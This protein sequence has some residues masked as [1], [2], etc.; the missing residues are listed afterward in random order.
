MI[1]ERGKEYYH[2]GSDNFKIGKW[3]YFDEQ[4][5]LLRVEDKEGKDR[6][7]DMTYKEAFR[8]VSCHFGFSMKNLVIEKFLVSEGLFWVFTKKGKSIAVN[9]QT[10]KVKKVTI[11]HKK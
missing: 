2:Y 9:M 8:K 3:E 10:G 6:D 7:Y 5:N 1:K 4:G 11:S